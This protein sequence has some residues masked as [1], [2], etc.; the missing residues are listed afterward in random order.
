[1]T[2]GK[3]YVTYADTFKKRNIDGYRLLNQMDDGKLIKYGVENEG[4]RLVILDG[5]EKL[6]KKCPEQFST[7][8]E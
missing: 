6:R 7:P 5:I 3:D 4:H 2:L 1:M 8:Q